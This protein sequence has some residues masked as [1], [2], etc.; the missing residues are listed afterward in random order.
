L[1]ITSRFV[2]SFDELPFSNYL[3]EQ[4]IVAAI[5][6]RREAV[7]RRIDEL[8]EIEVQ[9][10]DDERE[11]YPCLALPRGLELNK[12]QLRWADE[13]LRILARRRRDR[14]RAAIPTPDAVLLHD[15]VQS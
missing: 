1:L 11:F 2:G 12:A 14:D 9:V 6:E 5:E 7:Q 13:M 4:T 15:R 8:E 3:P 10:A